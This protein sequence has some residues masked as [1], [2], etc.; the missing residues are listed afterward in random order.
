MLSKIEDIKSQSALSQPRD[1]EDDSCEI[2]MV[3]QLNLLHQQ[4]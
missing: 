3:K 2:D 4:S 1:G